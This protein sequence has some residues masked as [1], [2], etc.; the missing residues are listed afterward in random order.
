METLTSVKIQAV[1]QCAEALKNQFSKS[2]CLI[3]ISVG[4]KYHEGD[5]FSATI[6]LV[7]RTFQSCT[8]MVCDSLQR[9]TLSIQTNL[10]QDVIH[11]EANQKGN[12]WL[13]R[14]ENIYKHLTIPYNIIRW[15]RWLCHEGYEEQKRK[16]DLLYEISGLFQDTVHSTAKLFLKR[17]ATRNLV[18]ENNYK[19]AFKACVDYIK[20]ECAVIPLWISEGFVF[21]IYPG[22]R[23]EPVKVIFD[24]FIQPYH[25]NFQQWLRIKFKK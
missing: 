9:H 10:R 16:T 1:I 19:A 15:D 2:K 7:N 5:E 25:K 24:H 21:E 11:P 17:L 14:N 12:E 4:Q 20:E 18:N 23:P 3:P 6:E 22:E 8:I 13:K